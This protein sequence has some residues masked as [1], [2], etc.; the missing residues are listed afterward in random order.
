VGNIG[1]EHRFDY[2]AVGENTNLASRLEGLNRHFGTDVLATR[3]IQ[4]VVENELTSRLMGHIQVKGFA[5]AIEVHELLGPK[6]MAEAS[7]PW[8]EKFAVALQ[9]FRNRRFDPAKEAFEETIRLRRQIESSPR[10]GGET[11]LDDGPSVFYLKQIA[12]LRLNP[13]P[14]EWVGE[15]AMKEK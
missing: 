11:P 2:A 4:R 7:R 5:R 1:G 6:A 10:N 9:H 13:P 8:R 14:P 12:E 3:E 15:V